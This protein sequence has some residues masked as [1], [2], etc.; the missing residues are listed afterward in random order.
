MTPNELTA[1]SFAAYPAEARHFAEEHLPLLRKL[2]LAVCPSFLQHISG[3]DTLFPAERETLRWQCDS[4]AK[5]PADRLAALVAPLQTLSISEPLRAMDWVSTPTRFVA[6]WTAYLWSSGQINGFRKAIGDLFAAIPVREDASHRMVVVVLGQGAKPDTA[7]VLR[8]LRA[9]GV[10]LNALQHEGAFQQ[11]GSMLSAHAAKSASPYATWYVDGGPPE[12]ALR[13][14]LGK[15][16]SVSYPG[17]GPIR[18]RVL[19]RMQATIATGTAGPEQMRDRL[20]D[21]S[22]QDAGAHEVTKDPVLQ[23]FYTELFTQSSG[24]QI[25]STSF[26]QWTSRE[27]ARRAQPQTLLV[28]YAP[29]QQ[30]QD[31]NAMFAETEPGGLDAEGALRDAEMGAFYSWIEMSRIT[32]PGKLTFA[33]WVEGH[34]LAVV[35]GA[36]AAAGTTCST[37]MTL[38]AAIENFG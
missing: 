19:H 14:A 5:L 25:F 2:P 10:T 22:P 11:I 12:A 23:R 18:E 27:L 34:P 8:K 3:F 21:T 4:L 15:G 36:G 35:L 1:A 30:H 38:T 31:M 24:P 17:L 32:A 13:D 20:A 26:V 7:R 29:R 16:T 28:R 6:E 33:A 37:P 9:R